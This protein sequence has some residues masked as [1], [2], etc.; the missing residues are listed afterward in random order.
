M[1]WS[2]TGKCFWLHLNISSKFFVG[3]NK[4]NLISAA[5]EPISKAIQQQIIAYLHF[6]NNIIVWFFIKLSIIIIAS[7]VFTK[8]LYTK[9]YFNQLVEINTKL[10]FLSIE[11]PFTMCELTIENKSAGVMRHPVLR[12]LCVWWDRVKKLF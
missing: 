8:T 9:Q 7:S 10:Y 2:A 12:C 1:L 11:Y 4:F 5:E 3:P 6:F